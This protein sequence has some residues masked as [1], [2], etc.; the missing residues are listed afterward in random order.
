[1]DDLKEFNIEHER[2]IIDLKNN[3]L[4]YYEAKKRCDSLFKLIPI[5]YDLNTVRLDIIMK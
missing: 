3:K 2:L 5:S 4:S 1:M